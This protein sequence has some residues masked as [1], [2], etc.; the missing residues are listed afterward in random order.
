MSRRPFLYLLIALCAACSPLEDLDSVE[1]PGEP[2]ASEDTPDDFLEDEEDANDVNEACQN[3]T[4]PEGSYCN[5]EGSCQ[6]SSSFTLLF[7]RN[8]ASDYT[9]SEHVDF[10]ENAASLR[11]Y[12]VRPDPARVG[13]VVA[14]W[15]MEEAVWGGGNNALAD[16]ENALE[17]VPIRAAVVNDSDNIS[18]K[19]G[20]FKNRGARLEVDDFS[21]SFDRGITVEG[22]VKV[23]IAGGA[24][25]GSLIEHWKRD[26]Q[27]SPSHLKTRNLEDISREDHPLGAAAFDGHYL[28]FFSAKTRNGAGYVYRYDTSLSFLNDNNGNNSNAWSVH[29]LEAG[30]GDEREEA[31]SFSGAV[32][33]GRYIYGIP[34]GESYK[35]FRYDTQQ[36]FTNPNA[37]KTHI[38]PSGPGSVRFDGAAFDG[39]YVYM[40][41]GGTSQNTYPVIR[42]DTTREFTS[43]ASW[44]THDLSLNDNLAQ[45]QLGFS[46]A[47]FDGEALYIIPNR[48]GNI[49]ERFTP[50]SQFLKLEEGFDANSNWIPF[51]SSALDAALEINEFSGGFFDGHRLSF[52]PR[53]QTASHTNVLSFEPNDDRSNFTAPQGAWSTW[54][55]S[56]TN[57]LQLRGYQG[58]VFDGRY[59]YLVPFLN[60]SEDPAAHARMVRYDSYESFQN[61]S[62]WLAGDLQLSSNLDIQGGMRGGIFDGRYIYLLPDAGSAPHQILQY[63]TVQ[64][65]GSFSLRT[66]LGMQHGGFS[67]GPRGPAAMVQINGNHI[68]AASPT[69]LD[70]GWHH[71]AMTHDE[72]ELV[73]WL[74]GERIASATAQ[75]SLGDTTAPLTIGGG[76]FKGRIDEVTLWSKALTKDEIY[77]RARPGHPTDTSGQITQTQSLPDT[78]SSLSAWIDFEEDA[79][80][81]NGTFITYQLSHDGGTTWVRVDDTG[82]W[83]E[84]TDNQGSS[85]EEIRARFRAFPVTPSGLK[86]RTVLTTQRPDA[87][88]SLRSLKV[89]YLP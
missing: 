37:W 62:A 14:T 38:V 45:N 31:I 66:S 52:L 36:N 56:V 55:L 53:G 54:D 4:C 6:E 59:A 80:T 57:N 75:G 43:P 30:G 87:T 32:F 33:D 23:D 78:Q 15:G 19:F 50:N 89:S 44:N 5:D 47:L 35:I 81:P 20:S 73:L 85:A 72:R 68:V 67:G 41:P 48:S 28:Y 42:Y 77:R 2:D 84:D 8:E 40:I 11:H 18:G 10:Q 26:V 25:H 7:N 34:G 12:P 3:T 39:Q 74:D 88:P 86:I 24:A 13:D 27:V 1:W 58:A 83:A 22:W 69:P 64:T 17:A 71:L 76:G 82:N 70:A 79:D 9:Q 60:P 63:D 46:G 65:E 16:G 21:S 51:D 61:E 29:I 49:R